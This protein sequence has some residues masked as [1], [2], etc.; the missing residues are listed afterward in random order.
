MLPRP[1]IRSRDLNIRQFHLH[2]IQS[3]RF[4]YPQT[5]IADITK[6]V[7]EIKTNI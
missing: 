2:Y 7:V 1:L 5:C 6:Y 3:I 4:Q